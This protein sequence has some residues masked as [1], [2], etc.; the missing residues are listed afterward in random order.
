MGAQ[1]IVTHTRETVL[2]KPPLMLF[3]WHMAYSEIYESHHDVIL[4]E[5]YLI[6][7]IAN[8]QN[9]NFFLSIKKTEHYISPFHAYLKKMV[10]GERVEKDDV[11]AK[12]LQALQHSPYAC[13]SLSR[14]GGGS[15]NFVFRGFLAQPLSFPDVSMTTPTKSVIIKQ[16]EKFLAVNKEFLLDISRCVGHMCLLVRKSVDGILLWT[17][18]N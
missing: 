2:Y 11:S 16:S 9:I 18:E 17:G 12:I 4:M 8:T 13:T 1:F 14:L 10:T 7:Y 3:T 5:Y 15:V 6:T